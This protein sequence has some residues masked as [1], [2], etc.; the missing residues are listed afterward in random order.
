MAG[1]PQGSLSSKGKQSEEERKINKRKY[2]R[3]ED[4]L[5]RAVVAKKLKR[6][7][8]R[9]E[10]AEAVLIQKREELKNLGLLV[11]QWMETNKN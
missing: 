5:Q 4:A 11:Y 2:K 10:K 6:L 1:R 8:L 9:Q 3:T 7:E